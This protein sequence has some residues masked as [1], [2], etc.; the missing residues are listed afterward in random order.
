MFFRS[1][2]A[3]LMVCSSP[4]TVYADTTG[5]TAQFIQQRALDPIKTQTGLPAAASRLSTKHEL[6]IELTRNNVFMGGISDDEFLVL[7]G[8]SSQVNLR[9]RHR[10]DACWQANASG[11]WLAHSQGWFDEPVDSWHQFFGFPDAMRGEWPLNQLE[12]G[13]RQDDKEQALSGETSG[14]GDVQ[15]QVQRYFECST[16]SSVLR[17][18]LKL[19]LGKPS[20]FTGNGSVD[21]FIDWQSAWYQSKRFSRLRWAGSAGAMITSNSQL[22]AEQRPLIGFGSMAMNASLTTRSHFVLQLDWHTPLFHSELR[23]LRRPA[24][25]LSLAYRLNVGQRSALE[26]SFSEDIAIDTA[27]DIVVRLAWQSRFG[28]AY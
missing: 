6:Q 15:L 27:P 25:Q 24:A 10:W 12:Y 9:Y 4:L 21:T 18:G 17:V 8:E 14:F 22:L 1:S 7:D 23:E 26:L 5:N 11:S 28:R 13:Y 16:A 2:I 20:D 3:L 19:P